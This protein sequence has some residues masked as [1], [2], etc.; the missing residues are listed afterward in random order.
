MNIQIYTEEDGERAREREGEN[1]SVCWFILYVGTTAG[2]ELILN[3]VGDP[4]ETPDS[5]LRIGIAVAFG[6]LESESSD[7]RSSSL[8]LLSLSFQ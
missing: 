1:D 7:G 3:R 5:W 6:H 4:D 8:S 2:T